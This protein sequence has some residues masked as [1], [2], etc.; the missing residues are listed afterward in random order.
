[1]GSRYSFLKSK[2]I[3]SPEVMG[4]CWLITQ[5]WNI[6]IYKGRSKDEI[7]HFKIILFYLLNE[8]DHFASH[9][10]LY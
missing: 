5:I 7:D 1:M 4:A 3:I 6:E 8:Y 10:I 2:E 9:K